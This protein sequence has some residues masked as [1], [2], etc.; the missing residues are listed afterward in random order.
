LSTP[1]LR[2]E[3]EA[4]LD[5]PATAEGRVRSACHD[6]AAQRVSDPATVLTGRRLGVYQLKDRIGVGGMDI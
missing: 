1:A 6:R 5:M 2:R 4:L 3:V